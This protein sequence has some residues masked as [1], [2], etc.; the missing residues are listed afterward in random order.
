LAI[1]TA[2]E[3]HGDLPRLASVQL[4]NAS[5]N[6]S[7]LVFGF[8]SLYVMFGIFDKFRVRCRF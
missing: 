5:T 7:M 4:D 1:N 2:Y 3:D 6:H 8:A